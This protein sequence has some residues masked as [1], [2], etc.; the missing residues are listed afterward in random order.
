MFNFE[1]RDK[2]KDTITDYSGIITIREE[3]LN[4]PNNYLVES[5][6]NTGRPIEWWLVEH[7]LELIK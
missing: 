4:A 6:D 5:K 1:L 2:V 3:R 7:R